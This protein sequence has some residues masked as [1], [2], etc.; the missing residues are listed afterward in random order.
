MILI[1]DCGSKKTPF[2]EQIVDEFMDY[3]TIKIQDLTIE[4]SVGKVGI[5]ISGAPILITEIDTT[6]HL[7]K[8][9]WLK[10][11]NIPVFGICFGHQLIGLTFGA[12]GSRMKEDRDFQTVEIF[13]ECILFD[14]LPNEIDMMEDHCETISIPPNFKLIASSDV[15]VNEAMMHNSRPLFGVQFHPEVSGNH[16]RIIFQ[17]FIE[18]CERFNQ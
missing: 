12:F 8:V 14:K 11:S 1:I 3:E 9:K 10:D 13:E 17:N 6:P 7:E 16:G 15:C 5:I 2:I 18:Y 4:N